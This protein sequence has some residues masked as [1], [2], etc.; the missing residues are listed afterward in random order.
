M[1]VG[2]SAVSGQTKSVAYVGH[3]HKNGKVNKVVL[4][5]FAQTLNAVHIS[6]ITDG[7]GDD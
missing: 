2:M 7:A 5:L 6:K 3:K 4:E 1:T